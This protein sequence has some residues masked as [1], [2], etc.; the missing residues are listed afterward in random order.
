MNYF[1]PSALHIYSA[2]NLGLALRA[3]DQAILLRAVGAP[4]ETAVICDQVFVIGQVISY[5]I[6]IFG[7][8]KQY[9]EPR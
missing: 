6:A 4:E 2:E 9:Q 8:D 5:I 3:S 1:A 7:S